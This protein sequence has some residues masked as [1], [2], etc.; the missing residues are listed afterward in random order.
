[1][2]IMVFSRYTI[3]YNRIILVTVYENQ[4]LEMTRHEKH[5]I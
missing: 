5:I 3:F 1:M 2:N 4:D